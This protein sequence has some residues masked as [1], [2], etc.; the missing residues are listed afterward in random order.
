[1]KKLIAVL[2][3][4]LA[5]ASLCACSMGNL[6]SGM[7]GDL[8]KVRNAENVYDEIWNCVYEEY[9]GKNS[10][11]TG[12]S[13]GGWADYDLGVFQSVQLEK[14][15]SAVYFANNGKGDYELWISINPEKSLSSTVIYKYNSQTKTLTGR[16]DEQYLKDNFTK[17][18]F[19][20][21]DKSQL[22]SSGYSPDD[23]GEYTFEK[24]EY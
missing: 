3:A 24:P 4:I 2:L 8:N 20:W 10:V 23:L 21:N 6:F 15:N 17:Y 12:A 13:S 11:L 7:P 19:E 5:A 1:M 18:Y 16:K 22:F 14:I 9:A